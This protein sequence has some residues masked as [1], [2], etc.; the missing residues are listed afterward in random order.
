MNSYKEVLERRSE[1]RDV[2]KDV[3]DLEGEEDKFF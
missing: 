1:A 3:G 2:E